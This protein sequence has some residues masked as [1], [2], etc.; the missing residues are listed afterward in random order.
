MQRDLAKVLNSATG[1]IQLA[2][3]LK[4]SLAT[5]EL[6]FDEIKTDSETAAAKKLKDN[7]RRNKNTILSNSGGG[8]S[9]TK[10]RPLAEYFT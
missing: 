5:G 8:G 1:S 4:T 9:S 10:K 2:K 7:I 3:L 6:V